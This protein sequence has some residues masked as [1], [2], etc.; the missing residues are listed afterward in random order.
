[1]KNKPI[2]LYVSGSYVSEQEADWSFLYPKLKTL[3]SE[4]MSE[5]ENNKDTGSFFSCPAVANKFKKTLVFNN[6]IE[7][8]YSYDFTI[9]QPS[10][11]AT[12]EQYV[13]STIQRPP[14]IAIGP[15]IE[16]SLAPIF[17][18]DE[19]LPAYFTPPFFNK[20]KYMKYGSAMPG[21]FD[22]GQWFRPYS[23]EVQMWNKKG[24]FYLEKDEPLFYI[25]FKTNRPI[26]L[27]RFNMS[28]RL[29]EY[30]KSIMS[31]FL[32]FGKFQPLAEIYERFKQVGYREKILTEIKKNLIDEEPYKF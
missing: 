23:F 20:P 6:V 12:S 14:T 29:N 16:F 15:T 2:N 9:D 21:E 8:S 18:A 26:I 5:R 13:N 11:L 10:V 22:V 30:K 4:L 3:F 28:P 7:S 31:S 24:N 27:H 32:A 17:F 19:S 1:M 25:E